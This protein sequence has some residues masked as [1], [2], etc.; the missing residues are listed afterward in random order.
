MKQ[1]EVYF[2][3]HV[4]GVGFRFTVEHYARSY[5]V[6]GFVKNLPDG[7]VELVI[8]GEEEELKRFLDVICNSPLKR[9]IYHCNQTWRD[10]SKALKPFTIKY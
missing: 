6:T 1:L 8:E 3:G 7:R 10:A 9:H 4:Q 2:E 5:N